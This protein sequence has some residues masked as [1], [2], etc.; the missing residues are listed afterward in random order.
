MVWI[1]MGSHTSCSPIPSP[2]VSWGTLGLL[3]IRQ[4]PHHN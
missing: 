4:L 1:R 3:Y 2:P